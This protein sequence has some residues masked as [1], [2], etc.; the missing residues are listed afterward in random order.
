M[1]IVKDLPNE[2]PP[3][4][5]PDAGIL[6]ALFMENYPNPDELGAVY[7]PG[8]ASVGLP[9]PPLIEKLVPKEEV[10]LAGDGWI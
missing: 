7:E 10:G 8:A 6:A 5:S 4:A 3:A 1:V 9:A 2:L